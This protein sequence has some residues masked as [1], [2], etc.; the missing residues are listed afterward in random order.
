MK[1][2]SFTRNH[3]IR[4]FTN[5]CVLLTFLSTLVL[6]HALTLEPMTR[7]FEKEGGG[8][9]II[10]KGSKTEKWTASTSASWINITPTTSGTG[11]GIVSYIVS[12]NRT[13]GQRI[14]IITIGRIQHTVYQNGYEATI[15]P[16]QASYDLNGG[17]GTISVTADIGI[18]WDAKSNVSW[19]TITSGASG[20]G[21]G[22]VSYKVAE[23]TGNVA[24]RTG[25]LT[26][27][28]K[29]FTVTQ[30]GEDVII[31]PVSASVDEN[32]NIVL[33]NINALATTSW[34]IKPNVEWI[35]VLSKTNGSG[36]ATVTLATTANL[37]YNQ[38]VGTVSVGS[39]KFTITQAG[40]SQ[41]RLS[42]DP[43]NAAAP[44]TGAYGVINVFATEDAPWTAWSTSS[45]LTITDG[46]SGKGD[47]NI[48]YVVSSNPTIDQ[49]IG[50][51]CVVFNSDSAN[52]IPSNHPNLIY[53]KDYDRGDHFDRWN[54]KATAWKIFNRVAYFS[55]LQFK[56]DLIT[57]NIWLMA[58]DM[59]RAS[60]LEL[61]IKS[62][63]KNN[64]SSS[65]NGRVTMVNQPINIYDSWCMY[66]ITLD[67]TNMQDKRWVYE[68]IGEYYSP[69]YYLIS[70]VG[71][72]KIKVYQNGEKIS[73][74]ISEC[75]IPFY[76][77]KDDKNY[78]NW[79]GVREFF[80]EYGCGSDYL[81][82]GCYV[83]EY[84]IYSKV[85][86]DE[87]VRNL[88]EKERN[89]S[90]RYNIIGSSCFVTQSAE[91]SFLNETEKEF[92]ADG[93]SGQV[94]LT[95]A[96]GVVWSAKSNDTWIKLLS[97]K[98]DASGSGSVRYEVEPNNSIYPRKGTLTIA[99]LTYT[100]TQGV[101]SHSIDNTEFCFGPDGGMGAAN[102]VTESGAKWHAVVSDEWIKIAEGQS[103]SGPSGIIFILAPYTAPTSYRIGT[104]TIGSAVITVRQYGYQSSVTPLVQE[105]APNGGSMTLNVTV[106]FGAVWE[107]A[108]RAGWIT[109]VGGPDYTG[110]GT[111]TYIVAPNLTSGPRSATL[112][113][114]GQEV[115]IT[116]S[117]N[118]VVE[119][120]NIIIQ[121]ENQ[122]VIEGNFVTFS[123]TATGSE[124][125]SYQ[126][127]KNNSLL[128]G[129]SGSSYKIPS[130]TMSDAGTYMVMVSNEQGAVMSSPAILTVKQS[131]TPELS[132][133]Q[134]G[135]KWKIT[136]TGTL[137][138]SSDMKNWKNV[139]GTQGGA[140]TFTP[141]KGKKFY[142]AVQ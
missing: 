26:V 82:N 24:T 10:V 139:S 35:S 93:G 58:S 87:E 106:P 129:V 97:P 43:T 105:I 63:D 109:F 34:A 131:G 140:Y 125:L 103:G 99:G 40:T 132:L 91:G 116:Q 39:K 74:T 36:D 25:T 92:S 85:F 138:E 47:G 86:S 44:S 119:K 2:T 141:A 49:R 80:Y 89:I 142:R 128:I 124:P 126:W 112:Y 108:S 14:G 18:A 61:S 6:V 9:A 20:A 84:S 79:D 53:Y 123:V 73:E 78:K 30:T 137:Q 122:T 76:C 23:Y 45:W 50:D 136:F 130:V 102:F 98:T 72:V 60:R 32:S 55:G 57:F 134:V 121:P 31:S 28:G 21:K 51:I 101:R 135:S 42:I 27:C 107:A 75:E 117:E 71:E 8:A 33:F 41:L 19:I 96:N 88:Y 120:P 62:Y 15:S 4:F 118:I 11:D 114:A 133:K 7:T 65:K 104:I 67:F 94:Q 100:V 46:T 22:T 110:S 5:V 29:T 111:L 1:T 17:N 64:P 83:D 59:K 3:F 48:H 38:R 69:K 52:L 37:S 66:T 95:I 54:F 68:Y 113:V 115:S 16:T 13:S 70:S 81:N 90:S 77:G 56:E 12:A 127:F